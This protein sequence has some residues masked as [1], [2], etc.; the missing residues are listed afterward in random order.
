MTI[1]FRGWLAKT[2]LL[3]LGAAC[4]AP[5][6]YACGGPRPRRRQVRRP[7]AQPSSPAMVPRPAT[8]PPVSRVS[9]VNA[10]SRISM[11]RSA[12]AA[13]RGS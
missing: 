12:V 2:R 8:V 7:G 4:A 13:T 10:P 9:L 1:K 5:V 3:R 11:I 6:L